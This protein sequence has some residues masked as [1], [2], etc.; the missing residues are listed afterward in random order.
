MEKSKEFFK[1]MTN[2]IFLVLVLICLNHHRC[3]AQN[4][5]LLLN[6][7]NDYVEMS[8]HNELDFIDEMSIEAWIKPMTEVSVADQVIVGKQWCN[9][10]DFA[11]Y[12]GVFENKLRFVWN[13]SGN[14][15][16]PSSF[17]TDSQVIGAGQCYHVAVV[18]NST[19]VKFF[20]DGNL[21]GGSLVLG[22]YGTINNSNSPIRVG[23]YRSLSGAM[24][25]FFFGEL[26]E[27][28]LWNYQLSETEINNR[29]YNSLNGSEIGLAAYYEM[30]GTG[31]GNGLIVANSATITGA[32][33]NG[34][35]I[36]TANSP[37]FVPSCFVYANVNSVE[38]ISQL[39]I[40][41]NPSHGI[42]NVENDTYTETSAEVYDATGKKIKT[43]LIENGILDLSLLGDGV[44]FIAVP[45]DKSVLREKVIIN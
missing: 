13:T 45:S 4:N 14:C 22:S 42:F 8:D 24:T 40:Y 30:D 27:I 29:M 10:S 15:N 31:A 41:P 32:S 17:E 44:Y 5:A 11:Y 12:F 26:D 1:K 16:F 7:V 19:G 28:R 23:C 21:V 43:V 35:T 20:V 9:G 39:E 6:G 3:I 36:G 2:N 34:T 33:M 38:S 25:N 37:E 18:F